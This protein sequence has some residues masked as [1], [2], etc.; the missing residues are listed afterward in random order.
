MTATST[1]RPDHTNIEDSFKKQVGL[2]E[3]EKHSDLLS[4][5]RAALDNHG[6][7]DFY[8]NA[9]IDTYFQKKDPLTETIERAKAYVESGASGIFVPGLRNDEDI[10][11][12]AAQVNAPLNVLSLPGHKLPEAS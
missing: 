3:L 7:E 2:R 1:Y 9:R 5:I 12:I 11:A 10:Q 8:I 4:K 6:F